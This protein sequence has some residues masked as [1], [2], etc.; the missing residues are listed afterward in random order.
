MSVSKGETFGR[1]RH[2]AP[3]RI[4]RASTSRAARHWLYGKQR[5]P[6]FRNPVAASVATLG[7]PKKWLIAFVARLIALRAV[8][9]LALYALRRGC[10]RQPKV[11]PLETDKG[12]TLDPFSPSAMTYLHLP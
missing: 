6:L 11:S 4:E 3:Q 12:F 10:L 2:P 7:L 9:S 1:R 5:K 8:R